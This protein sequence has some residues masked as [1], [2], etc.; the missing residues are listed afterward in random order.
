MLITK[1]NASV[2]VA[3][4]VLIAVPAVKGQGE[5]AP[6]GAQAQ[7]GPATAGIAESAVPPVHPVHRVHPAPG[8]N[9][10]PTAAVAATPAAPKAT[11]ESVDRTVS[12]TVASIARLRPRSNRLR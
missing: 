6:P 8:A 9:A 5:A 11:G 4:G 2:T 1:G 12:A 10:A 7:A 3:S